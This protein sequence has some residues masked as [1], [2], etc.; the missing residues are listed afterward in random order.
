VR[1]ILA[2]TVAACPDATTWPDAVALAAA[3]LAGAW[4]LV[5]LIRAMS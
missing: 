2:E 5:A 4:V 3:F 1:L